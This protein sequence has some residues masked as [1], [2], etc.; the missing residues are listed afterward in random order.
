MVSV[1]NSIDN[2]ACKEYDST[3]IEIMQTIVTIMRLWDR[4]RG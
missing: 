3:P 2:S 1:N 4:L